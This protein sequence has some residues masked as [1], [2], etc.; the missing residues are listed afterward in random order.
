MKKEAKG[1]GSEGLHQPSSPEFLWVPKSS[2]TTNVN[3]GPTATVVNP[4]EELLWQ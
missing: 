1:V 2:F 4:H 3:S